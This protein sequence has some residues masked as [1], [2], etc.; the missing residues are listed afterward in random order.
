MTRLVLLFSVCVLLLGGCN[1][2]HLV[3]VHSA[4]AG[5]E[6]KPAGEGT[7]RL[8]FGYDR[9]T[10]AL[11]PRKENASDAGDKTASEAMSLTAISRVH[12]TGIESFKFGHVIATG[13][14]AA[15]V[16]KNGAGLK[17]VADKVFKD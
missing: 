16:A 5:I 14:A 9:E 12:V 3:Y 15:K 17:D 11:V 6:L 4:I 13:S 8:V 10:Y 1:A 2:T 7:V